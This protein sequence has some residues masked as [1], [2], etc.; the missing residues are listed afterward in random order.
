MDDKMY[1]LEV[2]QSDRE[3]LVLCLTLGTLEAMRGRAWPLQAGIWTV[4]RPIFWQPLAEV[5]EQII[6]VLQSADELSALAALCGDLAAEEALDR[7]IAV[8]RLRLSVLPEKSWYAG[9]S[10]ETEA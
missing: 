6:K 8:V 3:A 1:C 10:C 5:D 2:A 9:W 4:G 7:M